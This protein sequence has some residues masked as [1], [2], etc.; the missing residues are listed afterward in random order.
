[1]VQVSFVG[2][3]VAIHFVEGVV[4]RVDRLIWFQ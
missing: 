4:L 3:F 1:M 2:F